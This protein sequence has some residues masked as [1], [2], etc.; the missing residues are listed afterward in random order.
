MDLAELVILSLLAALMAYTTAVLVRWAASART[1]AYGAA[2]LFLFAM[3]AAMFAGALIYYLHPGPVSLAEGFWFA[4]ILMSALVFPLIYVLTREVRL[5]AVTGASP[6]E[7]PFRPSSYVAGTIGL[8]L[9]NEFLMGWVFSLAAGLSIPLNQGAI[10]F[11]ESVVVSPWFIFTM[12]GEMLL[13]AY[14]LRE[15]IRPEVRIVL[16]FQGILMILSPPALATP[17]WTAGAVFA[18]SAVMI[19]LVI[20]LLEFVAIH[21]EFPPGFARYTLLLAGVYSLMMAGLYLWVAYAWLPLFALVLILEMVLFFDALLRLDRF[22]AGPPWEWFR[23]PRWIFGLLATVFV[24]EV[25]MGALL[26]LQATGGAW[27][28]TVPAF[29]AV[30]SPTTVL[31]HLLANGFWWLATV[32]ASAWFLVMM[33]IEMG[34]L[35]YFKI[36]ETRHREL[37][38][39]LWILVGVFA[40]TT[41]LIPGFWSTIPG[42]PDLAT[43]PFLGW[44]MGIGSGGALAAPVILAVLGTYLLVAGLCFLFGRRA[45]CSVLC[46]M[47]PLMYQGTLMDRM[48]TFNRSSSVGHKYLGSRFSTAFSITGVV[49]LSAILGVTVVSYLN[50]VGSLHVTIAGADPTVFL[51]NLNFGVVWYLLFVTVPFVGTYNCVTLGWCPWGMVGQAVSNRRVGLFRLKVKDR[52]VCKACTTLDCARAC[53]IG[54]VD[55]PGQFRTRG[56]FRSSKCCGVGDCIESCP[57]DNIYIHDVRHWVRSRLGLPA[58][59][60]TEPFARGKQLPMVDAQRS[61]HSARLGKGATDGNP[62]R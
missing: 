41:V 38:L 48:K 1:A 22:S 6:P 56:E 46:G 30:G 35:V 33:G 34:A 61:A 12:G 4:A 17:A 16:V 9:V 26:D 43:L 24:A 59:R 11:L 52:E 25:F 31:G 58:P 62:A 57:Y 3:M 37:R 47:A 10:P 13:S 18:G 5:R 27:L 8:V 53:P 29:P 39:R 36:R 14:F 19:A 54:L 42:A 45:L 20:Y 50:S 28:M 40:S 21:P 2:I 23:S 55:M 44:T 32:T 60:P 51:Y 7:A 49:A 15:R